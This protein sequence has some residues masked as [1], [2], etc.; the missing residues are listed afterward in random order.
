MI[1]A[2]PGGAAL[3]LVNQVDIETYLK[4]MGEVRD[5]SWPQ[6]ALQVQA[7]AARTYALRAMT[8]AG[9]TGAICDD[10]HCQVYLGAQAEYAAMNKAVDSSRA[11]S[12]CSTGRSQPRLL[13][14]RRLLGHA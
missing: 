2:T 1:E 10:T 6:A 5:P 13:Q 11:R 7:I 9:T 8:A 14:R 3:R 12:W 4:G